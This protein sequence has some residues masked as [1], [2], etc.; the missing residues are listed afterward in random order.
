MR[1]SGRSRASWQYLKVPDYVTD[2][3]DPRL[4]DYTRLRDV[5]LRKSLEAERGLFVAEG[6]K[7]IRRAIA[8]GYPIR[9]VLT[10]PRWLE[11]LADV[12]GDATVYV[13]SDETMLG[14]AG[15]QVHRGALASMER[16]PLPPV[17]EVLAGTSRVVVLEDLVDHSNVGAIFRCA[18]AL[19]VEG[20]VLSPRCADPLYR[21]SVKVSMGAVFSIPY[22]R[23][24]DWYGGLERIR[25]AGH[26]LLALTPDQ[27]ATPMDKVKMGERVAL[28]L[29]SE[30]DGLSSRWM[31]E[32]DE[33]VCIPMSPAAMAAG[34]DSLNVVA[35]AAIACHSLMRADEA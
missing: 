34:V 7:V 32:A 16:L 18:A 20:I 5:D 1:W 12:L 19:G 22:G 3:A 27:S 29:G 21:R 23:M 33:S 13:V 30:G 28:L 2:A 31:R 26:T 15:F 9:S 14:V 10:T 24:D 6:E 8:A 17:E 11:P 4:T 25:T 35:A